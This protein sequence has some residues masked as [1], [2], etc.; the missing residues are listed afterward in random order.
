M[1][2]KIEAVLNSR[3]LTHEEENWNQQPIIRPIDFIQK[4]IILGY[5]LDYVVEK[6]LKT[7]FKLNEDFWHIWCTQYL[8]SLQEHHR[9]N[10]DAK[11]GTTTTPQEGAVVLLCDLDQ[12]RNAWSI[13][14]ITNIDQNRAKTIHEVTIEL[15]SKRKVRRPI[16]RVIPLEIGSTSMDRDQDDS[17]PE[18][19][20]LRLLYLQL[21]HE[22]QQCHLLFRTAFANGS[23]TIM[24]KTTRP[25]PAE[26]R[27][28]PCT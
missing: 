13:G 15:P 19:Q 26:V 7:S 8:A 12:P 23:N 17:K 2:A 18:S 20:L 21:R 24:Q 25:T 22:P 11:R 6:A 5:P 9:R 27:Q 14:R 3:P 10:T 4:D 1:L 16:N 28:T